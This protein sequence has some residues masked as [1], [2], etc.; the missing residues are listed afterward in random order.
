M[1]I[2]KHSPASVTDEKLMLHVFQQIINMWKISQSMHVGSG[3]T[4]KTATLNDKLCHDLQW[5][6]RNYLQTSHQNIS[7]HFVS[8]TDC[9]GGSKEHC[10]N[11]P[12][13]AAGPSCPSFHLCNLFCFWMTGTE[14]IHRLTKT[15]GRFCCEETVC[16]S[17]ICLLLKKRSI[18]TG[19][20]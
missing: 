17:N 1:D 10:R 14:N 16:C 20:Y 12:A 2:S 15:S 5:L 4:Q 11:H 18:Q 9:M 13:L 7:L 3:C 19:L 6:Q 8:I